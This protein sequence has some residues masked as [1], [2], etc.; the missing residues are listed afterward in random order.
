MKYY[1]PKLTLVLQSDASETGLGAAI[2]QNNQP[3][4]YTSR[5]LTG[6]LTDIETR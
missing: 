4:E 1:D 5:A 2:M 6:A 3:I